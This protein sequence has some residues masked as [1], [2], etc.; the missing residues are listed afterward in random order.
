MKSTTCPLPP[1]AK[2]EQNVIELPASSEAENILPHRNEPERYGLVRM[3]R[4]QGQK[5]SLPLFPFHFYH[6]ERNIGIDGSVQ[7][8]GRG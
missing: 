3:P 4:H 5:I 2:T 8:H 6:N 7:N 1:P